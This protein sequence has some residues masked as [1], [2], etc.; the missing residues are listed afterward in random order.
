MDFVTSILTVQRPFLL[1][2]MKNLW[3]NEVLA[4][5]IQYKQPH[6]DLFFLKN[7]PES[8]QLESFNKERISPV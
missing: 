2:L 5:L 1:V 4:I 6:T 8:K 7:R 3:I